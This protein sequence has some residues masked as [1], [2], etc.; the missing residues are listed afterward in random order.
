MV[1]FGASRGSALR[2][3][4]RIGCR[5][6][7]N[8]LISAGMHADE[9]IADQ[10]SWRNT[11]TS[12]SA[13]RACSG[14]HS[15]DSEAGRPRSTFVSSP[16]IGFERSNPIDGR[17]RL[18]SCRRGRWNTI[19]SKRPSRRL[20]RYF[21]SSRSCAGVN[22]VSSQSS[23]RLAHQGVV[24]RVIVAEDEPAL[25]IRDVPCRR[26]ER[27]RAGDLAD[28]APRHVDAV[29]EHGRR[30]ADRTHQSARRIRRQQRRLEISAQHRLRRRFLVERA[31]REEAQRSRIGVLADRQAVER[32]CLDLLERHVGWQ[33][34]GPRRDP[35]ASASRCSG[36]SSA[37]AARTRVRPATRS[38]GTDPDSV[39][40]RQTSQ[41]GDIA[42]LRTRRTQSWRRRTEARGLPH[43]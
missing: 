4:P 35:P 34:G 1:M 11:R 25:P 41:Y 30:E 16:M 12:Q 37:P 33:R 23:L 20:A 14:R 21:V 24:I 15:R 17:C 19:Q 8:P 29:G 26:R 6:G 38:R 5:E 36:G 9:E 43:L 2:S 13:T 22:G 31:G 28:D 39:R 27:L 3:S 10:P 7:G 40:A 32:E 42:K 18:R